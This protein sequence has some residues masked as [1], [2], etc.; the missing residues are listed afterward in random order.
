[1]GTT[2]Y[3]IDICLV[4]EGVMEKVATFSYSFGGMSPPVRNAIVYVVKGHMSKVHSV[5]LCPTKRL[6]IVNC[7]PVK[8]D[9]EVKYN[10][11]L[12]MVVKEGWM[13][14]I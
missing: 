13:I 2:K 8:V 7:S 9:D 4:I 1:M 3:C 5:I 10:E 14:G 12:A 6:T 11:L